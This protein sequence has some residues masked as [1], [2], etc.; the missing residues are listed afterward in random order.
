MSGATIFTRSVATDDRNVAIATEFDRIGYS[1][2][3]MNHPNAASSYAS[4]A[5]DDP[6]RTMNHPM[7]A[8]NYRDVRTN[9][10][11]RRWNYPNRR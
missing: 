4:A 8:L 9:Y 10:S 1:I 3:P 11:N 5:I 2:G 7:P 6:N